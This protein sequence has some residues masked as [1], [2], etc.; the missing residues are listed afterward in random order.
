MAPDLF[1]IKGHLEQRKEFSKIGNYKISISLQ[2][3]VARIPISH[4]FISHC[5]AQ[6]SINDSH[7]QLSYDW[8]F[9]RLFE[10]ICQNILR[11]RAKLW[12]NDHYCNYD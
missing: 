1:A 3:S 9:H 10:K 4:F 2:S 12:I 11:G 5:G 6:F 7:R 8:P